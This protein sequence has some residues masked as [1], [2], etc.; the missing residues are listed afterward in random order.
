MIGIPLGT[1]L[2]QTCE[3]AGTV[4]CYPVTINSQYFY[5]K[6]QYHKSVS[7]KKIN[8]VGKLVNWFSFQIS[9]ISSESVS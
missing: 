7:L 8:W 3:M 4:F 1:A 2:L 9:S 6:K 5:S